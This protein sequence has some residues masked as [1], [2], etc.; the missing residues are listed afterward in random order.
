MNKAKRRITNF[1]FESEGAHVALVDKAANLQEVL[2]M[3][4]LKASEEEIQKAVSVN[5]K[6]SL[7]EFLTR[8]VGIWYEDAQMIAGMLG[9][10]YEDLY[11]EDDMKTYEDM[12]KENM[13][14]VTI[15]KSESSQRFVDA[16]NEY[17]TKT[18]SSVEDGD[19][20]SGKSTEDNITKTENEVNTMSTE[21]TQESIQEMV[22]KAAQD[23]VAAHKEA[24]EKAANEKVEFLKKQLDIFKAAA[25]EKEKQEY[26]AKAESFAKYMGEGADKE[27][28]AKALAAVEKSEETS[29]IKDVLKSLIDTLEKEDSFV[30]KGV[31][32]TQDQPTDDEAKVVAL[33]KSF[34]EEGMPEQDAYVK[35]FEKIHNL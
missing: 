20:S 26:L 6:L 29:A 15:E 14:K 30:E 22:A 9:Y 28:I 21:L 3:K 5:L 19:Y 2:V 12:V 11:D 25:E 4:S 35:A 1:N 10:S 17:L 27:V 7:M 8:Y 13:D 31:T 24:V 18:S 23:A 33:Q 16:F 34:V 32:T